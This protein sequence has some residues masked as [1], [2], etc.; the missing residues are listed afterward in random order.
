MKSKKVL[1]WT[2]ALAA[3]ILVT[4]FLIYDSNNRIVCTEY[5]LECEN[6]PD[7]FDGFKIVQLSD[8]HEKVFKND[9]NYLIS[10][11][12]TQDPDII[13]ITGD[14]VDEPGLGEYITSL[15]SEL[16]KIAPVYYVTG[17]HEWATREIQEVFDAVEAGGGTVLRNEYVVL[18]KDG[19]E[20]VVAGIDDPNGPYDMKTPDELSEEID[21]ECG[22]VF[23]VL[24]AHRNTP[25]TYA[26]LG[27][28]V[29]LCGHAH[30]GVIRLPFVGALLGTNHKLFPEYT[31]GVYDIG[32]GYMVVSRG[33][34]SGI[35]I[36]RFLNN[37]HIPVI[38]LKSA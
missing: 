4:A 13:A 26:D 20:I 35:S 9:N 7:S 11:V 6:L 22:D 3:M 15:V 23:K 24:L 5:Q 27:F 37:P 31:D 25:E 2:V 29:T 38:V 19:Q 33:L 36:P 34:G 18:E 1:K 30:G 10:Q 16:S 12:S 28:D 14:L 21:D 32:G 17:N 8:L